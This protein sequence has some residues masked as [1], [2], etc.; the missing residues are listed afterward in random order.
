MLQRFFRDRKFFCLL[1]AFDEDLAEKARLANCQNCGA[2]LHQAHFLRKPRGWPLEIDYDQNCRF[3]FCCYLCR[4]RSTPPSFRFLGRR[5]YFSFIF[6]LISAMLGG[7]SPQRR[8][9][10]QKICGADPRTLAR[11]KR[12]WNEV[13]ARSRFWNSISHGF[14]LILEPLLSLPRNLLRIMK[15]PSL[16]EAL[17]KLLRLLI[18]LS[19]GEGGSMSAFAHG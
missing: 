12:W 6:L 16:P 10:L 4:K 18:P 3:S 5:V 1:F 19:N 13:F 17:L 15:A 9:R 8:R 7:A 2:A 11:W 14:V